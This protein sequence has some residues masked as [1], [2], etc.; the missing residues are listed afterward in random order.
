MPFDRDPLILGD[1]DFRYSGLTSYLN[2]GINKHRFCTFLKGETTVDNSV[3]KGILEAQGYEL[4]SQCR[5]DDQRLIQTLLGHFTAHRSTK[6]LIV[7]ISQDNVIYFWEMRANQTH[8]DDARPT[9]PA[10]ST[11]SNGR[12]IPSG[13]PEG[14]DPHPVVEE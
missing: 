4:A 1:R 3:L 10:I 7:E 14:T 11:G 5:A 2:I 6:V 12:T 8:A 13:P 9:M